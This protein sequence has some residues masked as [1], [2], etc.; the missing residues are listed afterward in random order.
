MTTN[1]LMEYLIKGAEKRAKEGMPTS[2]RYAVP[3]QPLPSID[4]DRLEYRVEELERDLKSVQTV[5][6]QQSVFIRAL[7]QKLEDP[8]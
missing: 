6:V 7:K 1:P 5:L 4:T 3:G 2:K 8:Q